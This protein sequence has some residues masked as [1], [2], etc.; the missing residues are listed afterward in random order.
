MAERVYEVHTLRHRFYAVVL[1]ERIAAFFDCEIDQMGQTKPLLVAG[2]CDFGRWKQ[3]EPTDL[4]VDIAMPDF[5]YYDGNHRDYYRCVWTNGK[6]EY[7]LANRLDLAGL[8]Y[9]VFWNPEVLEM[10]LDSLKEGRDDSYWN[11]FSVEQI[12]TS[13]DEAVRNWNLLRESVKG[14]Y[15]DRMRT[16][17]VGVPSGIV[18]VSNMALELTA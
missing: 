17:S 14:Q 9:Y 6:Y 16:N 18:A 13:G 15:A 5:F 11:S 12:E 10:H 3:R 7:R 2:V 4:S 1:Q 8:Q